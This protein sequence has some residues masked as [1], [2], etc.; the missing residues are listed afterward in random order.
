MNK[1]FRISDLPGTCGITS[2]LPLDFNPLQKRKYRVHLLALG[3]VGT[4]ILIGLRL[5]G[6]D[7]IESIGISDLNEKNMQRL[8]M[9]INQIR[10]PFAQWPDAGMP[11][12][13]PVKL[14]KEADLFDCDV[15][16]FCATKG[17]PPVGVQGDVRMAQL[18][19]NSSLVGHF[20]ELAKK[21]RYQ[22]LFCEVSDPV[23]P[24]AKVVL[25]KSG[26]HPAQIQGYGLGVMNARACYFAEKDA[27][28][29]HYLTEG[30]AFGPHGEDLVIADSITNYNEALSQKLTEQT[31]KANLAVR[32]LGYK[33]YI[34]PA[35]S[36]AAF[37][38]ILT[39]QGKWHYGSVYLGDHTKG[40]YFGVRNR[41]T[42]HGLEYE[43]IT[44]DQTLFARLQKAYAN[45]C[46]LS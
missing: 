4:T 26:L 10:Y 9:E 3:D 14:V 40:A 43:N 32:E 37:S 24:L 19:A 23:D 16:I 12:L 28:L 11:V 6:A 21:A 29:T 5:L 45:L 20:A 7:I 36:S 46:K 25:N 39:L 18:A 17:V 33:P 2:T 42:S 15:F 13:P 27:A 38:I 41:Y 8:E 34:A 22:G 1:E 31:V 35:M 44:V 30:R